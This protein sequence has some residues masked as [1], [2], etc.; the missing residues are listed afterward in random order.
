[1]GGRWMYPLLMSER[2]HATVPSG[3]QSGSKAGVQQ[4]DNSLIGLIARWLGTEVT[5]SDKAHCAWE[6]VR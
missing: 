2:M 1:M 5:T 4:V 6:S 3:V